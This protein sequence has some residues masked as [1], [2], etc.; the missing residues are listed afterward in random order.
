M[1]KSIVRRSEEVLRELET[2]RTDWDQSTQ[3]GT[4]TGPQVQRVSLPTASDVQLSFFQLDDPV[5]EQVREQ[6]LDLNIDTLTPL[7]AL[8][9][10]HEIKKAV[11]GASPS[12]EG[13]FD[14][15]L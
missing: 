11:S 9:K 6:I 1:P 2:R 13:L 5:L 7:D 15:Q 3:T 8:L 10:L 14:S 4:G 12:N